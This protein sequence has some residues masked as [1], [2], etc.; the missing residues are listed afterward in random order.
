MTSSTEEMNRNC[1]KEYA[2]RL[3]R[4]MRFVIDNTNLAPK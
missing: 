2:R 4:D 3:I 1:L